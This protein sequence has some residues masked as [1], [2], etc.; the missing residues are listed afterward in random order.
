MNAKSPAQRAAFGGILAALSVVCLIAAA[1]LPAGRLGFYFIA[2]FLPATAVAE[3]RRGLAA[4][5]SAAACGVALLLLPNKIAILP[6]ACFWP[7]TRCCGM[8]FPPEPFFRQAAAL[9]C[10]DAG[11]FVGIPAGERFRRRPGRAVSPGNE[12]LLWPRRRSLA[13]RVPCADFFSGCFS[14]TISSGLSP[15][16]SGGDPP[17]RGGILRVFRGCGAFCPLLVLFWD[18]HS[19]QTKAS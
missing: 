5:C 15:G 8:C 10:F 14:N 7:G 19:Y 16:F 1:Y 11:S 2:A 18:N 6:Y 13:D 9:L 4:L 12:A 17:V 3:G